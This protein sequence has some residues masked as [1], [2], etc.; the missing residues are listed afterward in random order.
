L[1]G[2]P[3]SNA[4]K[5]FLN[6]ALSDEAQSI[7]ANAGSG[8]V[9]VNPPKIERPEVKEIVTE[10]LFATIDPLKQNEMLANARDVFK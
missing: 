10:K 8:T 7:F 9:S 1:K 3:H 2:A 6:F 5:M 4:A